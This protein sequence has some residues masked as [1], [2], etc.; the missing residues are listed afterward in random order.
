MFFQTGTHKE[1]GLPFNPLKAIIAPRPIGWISSISKDGIHNLAPYSFFNAISETPAM[2]AFSASPQA[3]GHKDSVKN[4][5]DVG[6]FV[7][8]IVSAAL[9]DAMNISSASVAPDIS[10][11]ETAKLTPAPSQMVSSPHVAEAP[12]YLECKLWKMIDLPSADSGEY[13]KLV[14]G[15]IVG[16]GIDDAVITSDG[17]VDTASFK[18]VARLGY[19]DYAIINDVFELGRPDD[20]AAS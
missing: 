20:P 7:V 12:C 14:I 17:K 4:I 16:I 15:E 11:F 19:K 6:D 1:H 10:E 13:S 9:I 18:P 8:N 3:A 2:V 5:Q